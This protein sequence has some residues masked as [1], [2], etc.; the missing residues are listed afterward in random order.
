MF[1]HRRHLSAVALA[2]AD[3]DIILLE[4]KKIEAG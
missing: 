3:G 1:S 2:K 4:K